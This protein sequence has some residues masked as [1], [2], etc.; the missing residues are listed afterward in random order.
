MSSKSELRERLNYLL[1]Y[2]LNNFYCHIIFL[3][4]ATAKIVIGAE[5]RSA[6]TILNANNLSQTSN[7]RQCKITDYKRCNSILIK[8]YITHLL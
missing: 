7:D 5:C 6:F 4:E 1:C 3:A 8:L 2:F